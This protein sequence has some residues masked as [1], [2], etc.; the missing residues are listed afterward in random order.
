M[1][2]IQHLLT[3]LVVACAGTRREA[4]DTKNMLHF[5]TNERYRVTHNA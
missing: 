5:M 3:G 4:Y 1:W 2:Q